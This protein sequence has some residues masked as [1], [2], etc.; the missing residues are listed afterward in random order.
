M[1]IDGYRMAGAC[2]RGAKEVTRQP[3]A[4]A[5]ADGR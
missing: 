3:Y 1:L 5:V 4:V 2:G